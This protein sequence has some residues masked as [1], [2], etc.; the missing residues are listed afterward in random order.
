[1]SIMQLYSI[2]H[3]SSWEKKGSMGK[4][5]LCDTLKLNFGSSVVKKKKLSYGCTELCTAPVNHFQHG[6]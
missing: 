2:D 1:M 3:L 4:Q 5:A 6:N